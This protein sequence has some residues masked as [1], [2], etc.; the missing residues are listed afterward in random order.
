MRDRRSPSTVEP[1][2]IGERLRNAREAKSLS[3]SALENLTRIRAV[4][5]RALEEEQ[6]D[7]L[8]GRIYAR[9][10]LRT[11]AAALGLDPDDLLE[12]YPQAF[13]MA[14]PPILGTHPVEIP[15]QPT[16][17]QSRLR[18]IAIYVGA[19]LVLAILVLGYIGYEQL[20]QFNAPVPQAES[21][22]GSQAVSQ[23]APPPRE[24][25][26]APQPAP[27][28]SAQPKTPSAPQ[29]AIPPRAP[30]AP[31]Q[32]TP[33]AKPPLAKGVEV[34][35]SASDTSWVRVVADDQVLFEGKLYAG[36]I[37]TWRA[38]QR[39]VV[40]LGNAPAIV[41]T[42]NG[43]QVQPKPGPDRVWEETFMAP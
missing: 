26:A 6:F 31:P 7:R 20:H 1:L 4:Y 2:G 19:V 38:R 11:Y 21:P 16:A 34:Q 27:E 32:L 13:Q 40:R 43:K 15:I 29:P 25:P 41:V 28:P 8:P 37:R 17:R 12:A 22:S 24:P 10:F 14:A 23:P 3:L 35:L 39:L 5:L 36:E 9:G 30:V 33:A 18:R 42:I